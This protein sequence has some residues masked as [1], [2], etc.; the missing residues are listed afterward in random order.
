MLLLLLGNWHVLICSPEHR[1][2][3]ITLIAIVMRRCCSLI[4]FVSPSSIHSA[5]L[6]SDIGG[7]IT[8]T[9]RLQ[10][11]FFSPILFFIRLILSQSDCASIRIRV[12][13]DPYVLGV[14]IFFFFFFFLLFLVFVLDMF[15][16][17]LFCHHPLFLGEPTLSHVTKLQVMQ[18][19]LHYH[20]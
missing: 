16:L 3:I 10:A 1:R 5:I 9:I 7:M 2:C 4:L 8:Q 20:R 14:V 13:D 19:L 18:L 11:V 6:N 17:F 15:L 12:D